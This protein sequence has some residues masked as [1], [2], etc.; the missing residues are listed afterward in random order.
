MVDSDKRGLNVGRLGRLDG[1]AGTGH[2]IAWL[3]WWSNW[4]GWLA[5]FVLVVVGSTRSILIVALEHALLLIRHG[6]Y[7]LSIANMTLS[8]WLVLFYLF[9]LLKNL[10]FNPS[11]NREGVWVHTHFSLMDL[12]CSSNINTFTYFNEQPL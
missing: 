8:D 11:Y 5:W 4:V 6:W 1:V 9:E 10:L 3:H 12:R 7:Q 2:G